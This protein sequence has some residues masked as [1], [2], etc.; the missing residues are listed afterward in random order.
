M[1]ISWIFQLKIPALPGRRDIV[2]GASHQHLAN[3]LPGL[4]GDEAISA[5]VQNV[6]EIHLLRHVKA[7]QKKGFHVD[8]RS[9]FTMNCFVTLW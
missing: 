7:R 8:S 2:S 9:E 1:K 6:D 4:A 5:A 3:E